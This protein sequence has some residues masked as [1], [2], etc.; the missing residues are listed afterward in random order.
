M[1]LKVISFFHFKKFMFM[2][3]VAKGKKSKGGG[4]K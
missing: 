3:F 2:I 4:E 1:F